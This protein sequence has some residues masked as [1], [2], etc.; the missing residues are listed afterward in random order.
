MSTEV[1]DT[2]VPAEIN[3]YDFRTESKAVFKA[4]KGLNAEVVHQISDIKNE[5]DLDARVPP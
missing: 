2:S 4:H 5:P 1:L 3:K